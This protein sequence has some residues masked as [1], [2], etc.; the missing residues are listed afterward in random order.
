M[1]GRPYAEVIGDP[2]A[3]SKSP[4]IHN[5]WLGKL[6]IDAEYRACHVRA[7]EL[8]EYFTRRRG[9]AEWRGC[10]ITM[11]HKTTAMVRVDSLNP[12]AEQ[13]GAVNTVVREGND[14]VGSNT[15]VFGVLSA[16]PRELMAPGAEVCVLGTGGAA[17]AAFAACQHRNV[18]LI[19]SS[20]RN[21]AL[22]A[23]LLHEFDFGGCADLLDDKNN[24]QTAEVII[25]AT[26]LGMTGC[27]PMPSSVLEHLRDPMPDA[28]VMDMV[29]SP[30]DTDFL[31]AAGAAGCRTVD[32]L[33]ML[34][35]QAAA[36]FELFFGQPAPR[37]H[38]AEL[39]ALLTV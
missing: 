22:G 25:N 18:A 11:P 31:R 29:Y 1:S 12:Y 9:D 5:F 20:S 34:I 7:G 3:H 21:P 24:I 2:I 39:R 26:S 15:D 17:R 16:L 30:L 36:A 38:D 14:L 35:G 28:V 13:V 37:E 27:P 33:A 23:T 19:L 6:G 8:A 4:L 10:N 32:G